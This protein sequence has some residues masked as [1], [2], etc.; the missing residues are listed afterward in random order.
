MKQITQKESAVSPVI[1]VLL[2]LV[3][4]IIIAAV[5]SGFAGGLT[6]GQ[7]KAPQASISATDFQ[8]KDVRYI[9]SNLN[10]G[11]GLRAPAQGA[12]NPAADIFVTFEH[13]GGE[14]I[15]L[16]GVEMHLSA[17]DQPHSGTVVS[18]TLTPQTGP[19]MTHSQGTAGTI[20]LKSGISGWSQSWSK[21]IEKFPDKTSTTVKPG[22]RFVLHADYANNNGQVAWHQQAGA[23]PF[24]IKQGQ[25]LVYDLIDKNTQKSISSGKVVVPE[26][27]VRTS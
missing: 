3:V 12:S 16:D 4:T 21:Y 15:N 7:E 18:R 6:G 25:V 22:E 27:S 9:G 11:Q 17:L 2:M 14:P 8:I 10:F 5:V 1:G 19:E 23:Y 24:F 13:K 26:F 20:G